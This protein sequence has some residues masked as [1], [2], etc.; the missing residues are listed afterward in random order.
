MKISKAPQHHVDRLRAWMQFNDLISEIEPT[1]ELSW[2][3]FKEKYGEDE[4][5]SNIIQKCD[6]RGV[7]DT[8][9][10]F[11][12]Y[13]TNISSIHGRIIMGY[14][15]LVENACDPELNYLDYNKEIKDALQAF[16]SQK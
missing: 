14:E 10:Y 5:F 13:S 3:D 16:E 9:K 4:D 15:V 11:E 8:E 2:I 12:Y 7:F 1:N 6:Y